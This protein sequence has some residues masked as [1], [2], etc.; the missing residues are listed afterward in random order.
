MAQ[1][2]KLALLGLPAAAALAWWLW[3]SAAPTAHSSGGHAAVKRGDFPITIV[4]Q[5][6][7]AARQSMQLRIAPEAYMGQLTITQVCSA[8]TA[9]RKDDVV[10]EC[11]KAEISR[12]IA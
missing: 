10:L 6:T 1:V 9:V 7:F 8:G 3:P 12:L 2:R 5:G 11:D 4:E